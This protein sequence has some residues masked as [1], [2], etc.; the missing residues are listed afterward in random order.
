MK[1]V[2]DIKISLQFSQKDV[3]NLNKRLSD[4]ATGLKSISSEFASVQASFD[5]LS[6]KSEYLES[7]S[8][9]N[10]IIDEV[11]EERSETWQVTESKVKQLLVDKLDL[12]SKSIEVE[13][14]HRKGKFEEQANRPRSIVMKLLR[15]KDKEEILKS[16][17]KLKGTKIFINEDF[18]D[19]VRQKRMELRLKLKEARDKGQ[20]AYLRY[21]QLIV[22]QPRS[23]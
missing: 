1:D 5:K 21:D 16:G 7:Q 18:T 20:I 2:Q 4:H 11:P 8:K 10:N 22:N 23:L 19:D 15:F 12:D 13:H 6:G 14:V 3:D 17:K 9:R